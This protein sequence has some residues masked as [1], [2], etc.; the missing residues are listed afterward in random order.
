MPPSPSQTLWSHSGLTAI[1]PSQHARLLTLQLPGDSGAGE[2]VVERM[3]GHEALNTLFAFDI[4]TLCADAG[5]DPAAL[6]GQE[7]TLRLL[8]ADGAQRAWHGLLAGCDA[9]GGDGGLARH[10]LR[11]RPWLAPLALRR[12][13]HV[14][15]RQTLPDILA[16]LFADYPQAHYAIEAQRDWHP[17]PTRVQYHE[18]DLDFLLRLLAEEGLSLRFEHQQ[19]G[20]GDASQPAPSR[21]RLVIF[22]ADTE[23]PECP[24]GPIRFHRIDATES[25]D[26]ITRLQARRR[27]VPQSV[28]VSSWDHA[29][30]H[31][32]AAQAASA[33]QLGTLPPLEQHAAAG[34]QRYADAGA[35]QDGAE[36]WLRH[37]E[38]QAKRWLG[39]GSARQLAPGQS[40][41]LSGHDRYGQDAGSDLRLRALHIWHEAAN[42]L[43]AQ[44]AQLLA[45]PDIEAGSYRNRFEALDAQAAIVPAPRAKPT[46]PEAMLAQVVGNED[47]S[48]SGDTDIGGGRHTVHTQRD[49]RV[50]VRF[51]WQQH[52]AG[53]PGDETQAGGSSESAV[54]A[55]RRANATASVWLRVAT[56]M[57]GPNW[58][59]HLLPRVGTEVL[60][61]F[62]DG[63]IDRPLV[64]QQLHSAQDLPPWSAGVD[65][66]A[67]H[68]G[69][70]EGWHATSVDGSGFNQWLADDAPAQVRTRLASSQAA[71]QLNLGHLIDHAPD[72]STRGAWRGTGAELRSD[73]WTVVRA[74]E[75]LLVSTSAQPA[76]AGT[77]HD[78][79]AALGQFQA[80]RDTAA[81]IGEAVATSQGLPLSATEDLQ[82][83]IDDLDPQAKG[84]L[85]AS[86][87]GQDA[88]IPDPGQRQ[89]SQ[90]VPA[91]AR[92]AMVF[93]AAD[94]LNA[95]TPASAALYGGQSL[96]W[97]SQQDWHASAGRTIALA[98]AA[99]AGLYS[100]QGGLK[101][102]AQ[103]GP[104]SLQ[105]HQGALAWTAHDQIT[106]TSS[107]EDIEILA[108]TKVTLGAGQASIVLDG[109]N[110]TLSMPATLDIKGSA[111]SFVGP[112]GNSAKL[113]RLPMALLGDSVLAL[114]KILRE[115][116]GLPTI[117]GP[118][119]GT[120]PTP[121]QEQTK[122]SLDGSVP[123]PTP[124]VSTSGHLIQYVNFDTANVRWNDGGS[125]AS[126][127][128][129]TRK[130]KIRVSFNR[131]G[132]FAFKVRMIPADTNAVYSST[133]R[134]RNPN[135]TFTNQEISYTTAAD[136]TRIVD[137]FELAAG[138]ND[139]YTF[140]VR[141]EKNIVIHTQH[142]ETRRRI[143]LQEIKMQPP[144]QAL[145]AADI[146]PL[147]SEFLKH[148]IEV[149]TN[150]TPAVLMPAMINVSPGADQVALQENARAAYAS[151]NAPSYEPYVVAVIYTGHLAAKHEDL[152][153]LR[154]TVTAGPGQADVTISVVTPSDNQTYYLWN[155]IVP[156]ED[157][158]ESA[159]FVPSAGFSLDKAKIVPR[160]IPRSAISHV[161]TDPSIPEMSSEVRIRVSGLSQTV[162]QGTILLKV[163][164][165]NRFRAGLA[166]PDT[167]LICVCTRGW[168][169]AMT[170]QEQN[171]VMIHELGHKVGMV[172][173]GA[174][175]PE[176]D[177][178]KLDKA[179]YFYET[180]QG[181]VGNHCH[182][183]IPAKP[184]TETY[185][186]D[187]DASAS[188]CVMFGQTNGYSAF[189][190]ECA[191]AAR[192]VDLSP[193][194]EAF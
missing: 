84:K 165:V 67:N 127:D 35:A 171:E 176:D 49:H 61:S 168:W 87:N 80:A 119:G 97:T 131:R 106:V 112:G 135:Y 194:W 177:W 138:G 159:T 38:G 167:N 29:R 12:D 47:G 102:I 118:Q 96:H 8:C 41:A 122:P 46:A 73:A 158:L 11:L 142:V 36:Q 144:V 50:Q 186:S 66:A 83:F 57:A 172:P 134:E 59:A 1:L 105:A 110:I 86:V 62:I 154:K 70:L 117:P 71:S 163:R 130:P 89:G 108:Q 15:A 26:S 2:L 191:K 25:A 74:G 81:R 123:A 63:D 193:G 91:F 188:T 55:S 109:A 151:S 72:T 104:V 126:L 183:G 166:F 3:S 148:G 76:A 187:A 27:A 52:G 5:F 75:G 33:L 18:S 149:D 51:Y 43:G 189:C 9:L 77:L 139:R 175:Y 20:E 152:I 95:A 37:W 184:A 124:A 179:A 125:I 24:Q 44:I 69:V 42:N 54:L 90:P 78:A 100:A 82:A 120:A 129:Q 31:A 137:D 170:T 185:T 19:D 161:P 156:G 164:V 85:P 180:S 147:K 160:P 169:Q 146:N 150:R 111:K 4:D 182:A 28:A 157:W 60:V 22:D 88:T 40:F 48:E 132:S 99:S 23:L 10:R 115:P 141:D 32:P 6:I 65:A 64:S 153:R 143:Y 113:P 56:P 107:G 34:A 174:A 114:V 145:A 155:E 178:S 17:Y 133:E 14:W 116:L 79:A 45:R 162:T 7:L 173:G 103:A 136:G 101:A 140:E 192:K 30:L 181:H 98:A 68:P 58:G 53:Q 128:A 92:S 16:D 21:H 190:P 13:S 93:D 121:P 94:S 39:E